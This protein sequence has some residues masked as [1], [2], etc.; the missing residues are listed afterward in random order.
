MTA[1]AIGADAAA[2]RAALLRQET[3]LA[4]VINMVLSILFFL[5]IFGWAPA[6]SRSLAMDFLPQTFGI[7]MLGGIV[8]GFLTLGRI[9]RGI[10]VP[11]RTPP[12]RAG[13]VARITL[14]AVSA[15]VVIGGLAGLAMA[16][17][18]PASIAPLPA[19]VL[20]AVYGAIL[21]IVVTPPILRMALGMPVWP[22]QR[23][24]ATAGKS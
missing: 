19:V 11:L 20:K 16:T 9:K 15:V 8:P 18:A 22:G 2:G 7:T 21:G 10:V 13:L 23:M 24:V 5:L 12:T 14:V 17:F 1:E 3:I 4:G 6:T